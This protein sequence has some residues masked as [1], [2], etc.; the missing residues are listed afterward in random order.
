MSIKLTHFIEPVS[1]THLDVYKRQGVVKE[2]KPAE[3]TDIQE[4]SET[5]TRYT[6]LEKRLELLRH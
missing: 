3:E 6:E 5:G 2:T 1:Y 4:Q